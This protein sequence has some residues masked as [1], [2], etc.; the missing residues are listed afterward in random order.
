MKQTHLLCHALY[1]LI[2]LPYINYMDVFYYSELCNMTQCETVTLEMRSQI[3]I[4][5]LF[6][7]LYPLTFTTLGIGS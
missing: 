4:A 2:R 1:L 7:I 5:F 3:C 6:K